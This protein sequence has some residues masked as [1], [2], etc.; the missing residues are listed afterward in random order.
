[1]GGHG[2]KRH[3]HARL[4]I[5]FKEL[6]YY[7]KGNVMKA[8]IL[9]AGEG[10]R[11]K[12]LTNVCPKALVP[13]VNRP[14][15]DRII[16]FLAAHGVH[17]IMVNAHHHYEK[18]ANYLKEYD[19]FAVKVET[20]IEKDIL[21][22]GGGIKNTQHFWDRG[23]FIVINGDI[24]TDIKLQEVYEYHLR[25]KNLV[26]LV[27]HDFAPH[28]KVMAND[29]MSVLSFGP[30]TN[31]QGALAFTGIHIVNP[32]VIDFMPEGKR[33]DIIAFYKDLIRRGEPIRAYVA[34]GHR[35]IDIGAIPDYVSANFQFLPPRKIVTAEECQ[36]H[37]DAALKE[38]AVI[39]RG[40][41]IEQGALVKRSV[42]WSD[43]IVREGVRVVDSVVTSGVVLERD[44]IGGVATR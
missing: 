1:M 16:E 40:S 17:E 14:V 2:K 23:P 25:C 9:A 32:E 11:L 6:N 3:L 18:M 24:L 36:L 21:G 19:R 44:L 42:L 28:N 37:P 33:H 29:A 7:Q 27:L 10:R 15:I 38:W 35:W 34:T 4:K 41:S 26:T 31:L 43:V 13:V 20:S 12:P 30:G 22:T 39:G 8:M 5:S